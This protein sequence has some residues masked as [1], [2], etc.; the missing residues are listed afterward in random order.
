MNGKMNIYTRTTGVVAFALALVACSTTKRLGE[1]DILYTGVKKIHIESVTGE[2]V[3]GSVETAVKEPLSVKPNNPLYSPYVRTP[4][5]I[6]LW[7]WNYFYTDKKGGIESWLYRT[8]AKQPVLMSEVK[9][10]LRVRLVEDIL[11]NHGYFDSRA[12]YEVITQKNPKKSRVN[13]SVEVAEPWFYSHVEF[14]G[15][16]GSAAQA[17]RKLQAS[18]N[19]KMG[20]QYNVDSLMLERVRITN[21]LREQ[22]YYYF[23]PEFIEYLADTVAQKHEVDLRMTLA[24]GI[25][26]AALQPY[27]I[28]GVSVSLYDSQ[29]SGPQSGNRPNRPDTTGSR[30]VSRS[31]T[32]AF[33]GRPG[34]SD[35]TALR[36]RSE[37]FSSF[38]TTSY[39]GIKIRYQKPARIRTKLLA[40]A[41][42]VQPG[43]PARLS[44]INTTLT[45]L[46]KL[47]IFR[48]VN[49]E[50]TPLDSLRQGD[51]LDMKITATFDQPLE[52][53]LE[54]DF[55]YK[56]SSFIGPGA[57]FSVKHNNL[58]HGGEV[59]S[60]SLDGA[61]EWQTGNNSENSLSM[62]SYE[63]GITTSLAFPRLIAPQ[64]IR[65]NKYPMH[66]TF[67]LGAS[68]LRRAGFFSMS[69][70]DF[71]MSYDF[72]TSRTSK[73]NLSLFKFTYNHTFNT[74]AEFKEMVPEGSAIAQSFDD[75]IIPSASYT[76][77]WN[78]PVG[79]AKENQIVWMSTLTSAGNILSGLWSLAGKEKPGMLFGSEFSQFAKVTSEIRYFKKLGRSTTLAMRLDGGIGYP[80]GNMDV[81]PYSEQF[82]IG[83][84]NSIRAFTARSIGPGSFV[85]DLTDNNGYFDQMGDMKIE[86]NME[87]RFGIV[88]G[89]KGAVFLDAGNIWLLR[90]YK[91]ENGNETRPGGKIG[92]TNFFDAIA[93]GTGAGLR[94]D[95]QFLIIRVDMGIGL[96]LPYDTGKKGYYNIPSFKDDG[97][98]FHLAIGYPF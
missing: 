21:R 59:F 46:T 81:L 47:G 29:Y 80:Y 41:L 66:T 75:Q 77:T 90:D 48:S 92:E 10:E 71:N 57:A 51:K 43:Q 49:M 45:N 69:S 37:R 40:R 38:D 36:S 54:T 1:N 44:D 55:S 70:F 98:A 28:G 13:Y 53:E 50:V 22:S 6:G 20:V 24:K 62:N 87:F 88:A 60:V 4:L 95:L 42:T 65:R 7:A 9:P 17:I 67:N 18:S 31:D 15:D 94:Y 83:G 74:S 64:F 72:Q 89:L 30:G 8:L 14:P 82:Y 61:Y 79:K 97:H 23:R 5:P 12:G 76:Y 33:R 96:H 11:D 19:V 86:G 52:A 58:F 56:S 27:K 25:P 26:S 63:A 73:H 78:K 68:M 39:N 85:P 84:A 3:H 16:E 32:T 93:L 91:D 34:G 2:E 35:T